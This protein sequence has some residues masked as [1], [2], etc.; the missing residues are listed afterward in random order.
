[1][2]GP[3]N[4]ATST[5]LTHSRET[6]F[7][8]LLIT[9]LWI[10]R[11]KH[12]LLQLLWYHIAENIT[13]SINIPLI[14]RS[15]TCHYRLLNNQISENTIISRN[16]LPLLFF[17]TTN[18]ETITSIVFVHFRFLFTLNFLVGNKLQDLIIAPRHIIK[19]K[20]IESFS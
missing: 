1:M 16:L 6:I 9:I 5:I 14:L 2:L 13:N 7:S 20:L 12:H 15:K 3:W 4:V 17:E 19:S 8:E 11:T 18:N 10:S